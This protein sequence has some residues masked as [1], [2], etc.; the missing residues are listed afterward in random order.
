MNEPVILAID[1]D[2]QVLAA[3]RRDL[4]THYQAD[5][6]VLASSSGE[7]ALVT[8]RE[9]KTRGDALAMVISDQRMPVMLGVDLLAKCRE[10]Y[11]IAK[12][13][14]LTAYSDIKAAVRAINEARLDYYLEKRWDPPE[15][16]LFPP[17][18]DLLLAWQAEYRP[19]VAG[20]RVVGH[21]WSPLSHAIKDFLG[22]NLIPYRWLESGRDPEARLLLD[23]AGIAP[24]ELPV[25]FLENGAVVRNADPHKVAE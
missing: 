14:L 6:R 17:I 11:P 23:A 25:T 10:L 24:N 16:K 20:L 3:L 18:D 19:E 5:Y 21:P 4:R 2:P 9:L 13:V 7:A 15:E 22:S 8:V 1:D 12:R